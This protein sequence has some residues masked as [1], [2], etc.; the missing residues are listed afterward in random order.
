[1]TSRKDPAILAQTEE[2]ARIVTSAAR[3]GSGDFY[4][5]KRAHKRFVSPVAFEMDAE[6]SAGRDRYSVALH[7]VS[8]SGLACWS[9]HR[10]ADD[11]PVRLREF[12]GDDSGVWLSARITHCTPGIRG[13]LIGAEFDHP[14][15][16]DVLAKLA[17]ESEPEVAPEP[18]A[19]NWWQ[20][21]RTALGMEPHKA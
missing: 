21:L 8:A 9:K 1:M 7:D 3:T 17:A 20:R 2:I 5:G 18:A 16:D 6:T 14:A 13:F 4:G 12:S 10:L 11:A 19:P 15:G